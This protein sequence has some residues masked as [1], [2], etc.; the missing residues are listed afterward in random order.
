MPISVSSRALIIASAFTFAGSAYAE[1]PAPANCD[2]DANT[3]FVIGQKNAPISIEPRGLSVSLGEA[4][5]AGVN[6]INAE[7]LIKYAPDFFVRSRYI[8]DNNA[9]PGF[10]GTHSTQSARALVMVDGFVVSNFLGNSFSFPPAWGIVSPSEIKQFDIVYGPYSARY[11]GNSMGGIVNITTRAP[12]RTEAFANVQGF[13]QPYR[14]YSTRDSFWGGTAEAGFGLKQKDGPF[15]ARISARRLQNSSQPMQFYQFGYNA[16]N[17]GNAA[18]GTA[19]TGAYND[20]ALI[21]VLTPSCPANPAA[22]TPSSTCVRLPIVGDYSSVETRQDQVRT[23]LRFDSGDVHV[24][25]LFTYWWN[26]EKTLHPVTYLRDAAGDPY[27]GSSAAT[28]LVSYNGHTYTLASTGANSV[29][30]LGIARKNEWL[31]GIKVQAPLGGFDVTL[32]LSTLQFDKQESRT[33][34][35][36]AAGISNGAG[37]ITR[38]GPTGWFTADLLAQRD[39]GPHATSWG[40]NANTYRTDR[41]VEDTT[42]WRSATGRTFNNEVFGKTRTIGVFAEDAI[43]LSDALTLTAGIRADWWRAYDGGLARL[44]NGGL[45]FA[46]SYASRTDH[47]ISPKLSAKAKLGN[48]WAAELSLA[49]ATRFPT[50]GE[51]FQGSLNG[52]GT[53]NAASFDP[54]LKPERSRDA[55]L[56]VRRDLGRVT[57]TSSLFWQR[58]HNAIFSYVGFNSLGFSSSSFKNIDITRQVGVELI[59]ESHNWPLDGLDVD[60]N[61]AWIDSV[62]VRNSGETATKLDGIT[63][64]SQGVQF[65]RIPRWRINGNI[66]YA[67][68]PKVQTVLGFRYASRPNTD[69]DG[70]QRGDT[71]GYTS[72]LFALDAKVNFRL[73]HGLRLSAGVNNITNDR[74]WVFHPFPQRTFLIVLAPLIQIPLEL[75]KLFM[76]IEHA[77]PDRE[78][79]EKIARELTSDQPEDMPHGD[80]LQRVLDAAVG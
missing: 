51:L 35:G 77:L 27:Y 63:P 57:L 37:Q 49:Q 18:A 25:G 56:L 80:D 40:F 9:V 76:V 32:N 13:V 11:P 52:D 45:I 47:A 20:P 2:S 30:N 61:A 75:E 15:S 73:N 7:D 72:E 16:A 62:T 36:Y 22:R 42:N 48:G 66:R 53:F 70:F 65:P 34:R 38:Q 68:T 10:R 64:A 50:V 1:T 14:Q 41:I 67:L 19:V 31:G 24:E 71:Y 17:Y 60:A 58:V 69:I 39:F 79:L 33:S 6:A 46:N 44:G 78:Q 26:V 55:N 29:F 43:A 23:Q 74:A 54:N 21:P 8:G 12:E 5:F 4:Q 28:P 3:I 59:G